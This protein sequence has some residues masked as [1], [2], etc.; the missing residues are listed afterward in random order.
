VQGLVADPENLLA[1]DWTWTFA[2]ERNT[3]K[4]FL[5]PE[6]AAAVHGFEVTLKKHE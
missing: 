5:D 6:L 2:G 3:R 1:H 4:C